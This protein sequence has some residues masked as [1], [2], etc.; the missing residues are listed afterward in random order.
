MFFCGKLNSFSLCGLMYRTIHTLFHNV[1]ESNVLGIRGFL[2]LSKYRCHM[3]VLFVGLCL[4]Q[5]QWALLW[6]PHRSLRAVTLRV[7][8]CL[9]VWMYVITYT[10]PLSCL[11]ASV[12]QCVCRVSPSDPASLQGTVCAARELWQPSVS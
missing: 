3:D 4:T 2:A 11:L 8:T 5:F 6:S 12:F 1:L 10:M 9:C 7:H